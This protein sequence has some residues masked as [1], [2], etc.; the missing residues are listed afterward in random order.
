MEDKFEFKPELELDQ[1]DISELAAVYGQPGFKVICKIHRTCVDWFIKQLVNTD[2]VKKDDVLVRHMQAQ[3]AAQLYTLMLDSINNVVAE[4]I[5]SRPSDKPV[6]AAPG[7]DF[8]EDIESEG[9]NIL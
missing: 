7:L 2:G 1:Q 3:V 9:E 6:N 8:G 5:H 4:Y